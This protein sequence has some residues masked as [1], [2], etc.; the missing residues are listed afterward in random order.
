MGE[1]SFEDANEM[2]LNP[3]FNNSGLYTTLDGSPNGAPTLPP[4]SY[5]SPMPS[6]AG[7]LMPPPARNVIDPP[8][9]KKKKCEKLPVHAS[10]SLSLFCCACGDL[11]YSRSQSKQTWIPKTSGFDE[12]LEEYFWGASSNFTDLDRYGEDVVLER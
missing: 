10:V 3:D 11:N 12:S 7:G 5:P 2:G 9:E 8:P 4:G 6:Y 1:I